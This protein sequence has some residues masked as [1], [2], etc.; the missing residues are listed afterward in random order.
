MK[1]VILLFLIT[2]SFASFILAEQTEYSYKPKE[3]YVASAETAIQI[4]M[5]ILVPIYGKKA[6][7]DEKPLTAVLKDGVWIVTGTLNCPIAQ[8]LGG[9]AEIEISKEDGKILKVIHGQ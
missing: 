2:L 1:K 3:G 8:C 7:D 6:I 4:A 9:V 5:A